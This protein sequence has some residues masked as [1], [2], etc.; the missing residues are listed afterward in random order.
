MIP[1]GAHA[2]AATPSPVPHVSVK[3]D[4]DDGS[5]DNGSNSKAGNGNASKT[6][7]GNTSN[8]ADGNQSNKLSQRKHSRDFMRDQ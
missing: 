3:P 4:S 7:N 5:A 1:H 8:A 6:D 2:P